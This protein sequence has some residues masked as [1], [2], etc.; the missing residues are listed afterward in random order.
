MLHPLG[1][2]QKQGNR[3]MQRNTTV[4]DMYTYRDQSWSTMNLAGFSVEATDGE[5]GS[6]DDEAYRIGTDALLVNTGPWIFGKGVLL[7]AGVISRI[8][9]LD[10]KVHVNLTKDQIK[11]APEVNET[12]W[13]DPGFRDELGSYYTANRPAGPDY[14]KTDTDL[15]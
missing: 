14:G 10:R 13:R 12:N 11:N 9:E 15:R 6:V 1:G 4:M 2:T 3:L 5:V 7:P 8:D